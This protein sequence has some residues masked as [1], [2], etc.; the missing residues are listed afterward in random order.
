MN[1]FDDWKKRLHENFR[2]AMDG[3]D[4]DDDYKIALDNYSR[5]LDEASEGNTAEYAKE[6]MSLFCDDEDYGVLESCLS[7]LFSID[8][9]QVKLA[10]EDYKEKLRKNSK[11]WYE[12]VYKAAEC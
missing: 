11:R 6:L 9:D 7:T 10:F 3:C 1:K 2:I 12:E 5:A 4:N 8:Q